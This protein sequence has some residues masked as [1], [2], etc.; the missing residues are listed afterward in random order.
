MINKASAMDWLLSFQNSYVEVLTLHVT[1]F[2]DRT[3]KEVKWAH[4]TGALVWWDWCPYEKRQQ[5][6]LSRHTYRGKT[7]W[8]PRRQLFASQEE[9]SHRKPTLAPWPWTFSLRNGERINV[10]ATQ[11][12]LLL[13]QP[14]L[15]N[16]ASTLS[17]LLRP[18]PNPLF[19]LCSS[20]R[21]TINSTACR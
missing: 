8:G 6:P 18:R 7:T 1:E 11:S 21:M 4:K 9:K 15:T 2:G 5:R 3:F 14:E 12:D 19:C 20:T 13:W 16:A 17:L 10:W